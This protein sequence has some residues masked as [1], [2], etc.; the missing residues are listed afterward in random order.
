MIRSPLALVALLL[1]IAA[2]KPR[3][4]A[5]NAYATEYAVY[6]AVLADVK[7]E[8]RVAQQTH[9]ALPCDSA[10]MRLCDAPRLPD[11]YRDALRDYVRNGAAPMVLPR[12]PAPIRPVARWQVPSGATSRCY[13]MPTASLSRVGFSTDSTHAVVSY[14]ES[15]GPGP[16]PGCGYVGGKLLLLRRDDAGEWR[17]LAVVREWIT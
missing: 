15:T 12:P 6:A 1:L 14:S 2:C 13:P 8:V 3:A 17:V 10:V 9:E 7:H 4:T 11:A 16:F 5:G